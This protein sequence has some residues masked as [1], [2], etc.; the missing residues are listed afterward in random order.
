MRFDRQP[1]D[2]Q[3]GRRKPP[4]NYLAA[5]SQLRLLTMVGMLM[6]VLYLMKEARKPERWAWMWGGQRPAAMENPEG[7][8][9]QVL[10]PEQAKKPPGK[11][12]RVRRD[13]W[14]HILPLL[15]PAERTALDRIL[16]ASRGRLSL[17]QDDLSAGRT[18]VQKLSQFW[19]EFLLA[20]RSSLDESVPPA[21]LEHW[22]AELAATEVEWNEKVAAGLAD[23]A[24]RTG[25]DIRA[26]G[27]CCSNCRQ[28][29]MRSR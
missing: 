13:A 2:R 21:Q 18:A 19:D 14:A 11:D 24:R 10:I 5:S 8:T 22:T 7:D 27:M 6:L 1:S 28:F 17:Q 15:Q 25:M 3:T 16:L 9:Y 23:S 26:A 12:P 20:A 29:W 4:R